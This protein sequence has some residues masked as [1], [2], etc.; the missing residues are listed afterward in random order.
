[1]VEGDQGS[2]DAPV[3][4]LC[5]IELRARALLAVT[6]R[7]GA[8]V[9]KRGPQQVA[10]DPGK[11]NGARPPQCGGLET[12]EEAITQAKI[13]RDV[14]IAGTVKHVGSASGISAGCRRL[15]GS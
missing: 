11:I 12:R 13:E 15:L 2:S 5:Q 8:F 1:V 7:R 9:A 14:Q 10:G 6:H 4:R 3:A